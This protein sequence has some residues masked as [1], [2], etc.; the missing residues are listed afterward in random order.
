MSSPN[1]EEP[2]KPT[3]TRGVWGFMKRKV[4]GDVSSYPIS[5]S[6]SESQR[7]E[8]R[9]SLDVS[10]LSEPQLPAGITPADSRSQSPFQS[11]RQ[12]NVA[13]DSDE[14]SLQDQPIGDSAASNKASAMASELSLRHGLGEGMRRRAFIRVASTCCMVLA[15]THLQM[16]LSLVGCCRWYQAA[17]RPCRHNES[18]A[19]PSGGHWSSRL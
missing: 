9:Q 2:S 8:S 10:N 13:E 4:W 7:T 16:C 12:T 14:D 15:A 5:D 3:P 17:S 1:S 11:H 6:G 19:I 18:L